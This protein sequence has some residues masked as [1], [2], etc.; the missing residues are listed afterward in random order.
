LMDILPMYI[1]FSFLTPAA[2]AAAQ[3]WGWK[4][5]L[6]VSFSAWVIAQTQ[7]RDML[8]TASKDL[9]FV[10]LGP[11]DLLAWQLL[12]VGG[13]F[14]GQRSL[15]NKSLLPILATT[16]LSHLGDRFSFLALDFYHERP[17]SNY[18]NMA[19]R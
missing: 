6:F 14:I 12:W 1:L 4:T 16:A 17:R 19:V 10:Q 9:P 13:L 2:F 8:I 3:R 5:V 15:E 11:F 18:A 7:V